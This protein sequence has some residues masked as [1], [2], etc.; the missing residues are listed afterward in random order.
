MQRQ[1]QLSR[2]DTRKRCTRSAPL[3]LIKKSCL[4]FEKWRQFKFHLLLSVVFLVIRFQ[5]FSH[6]YTLQQS[7]RYSFTRDVQHARNV[8][9]ISTY[10]ANEE[11]LDKIFQTKE[12][13]I[14]W[15][16]S[17]NLDSM[18]LVIKRLDFLAFLRREQFL[19]KEE[20]IFLYDGRNNNINTD[21]WMY[22]RNSV[23]YQ[24]LSLLLWKLEF[25]TKELY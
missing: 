3:F 15:N 11:T 14:V 23:L 5:L 12:N 8:K 2:Y 6:C 9:S 1:K 4:S 21:L 10:L 22:F 20:N 7:V 13:R 16:S 24:S 17:R 19:M 25:L 18:Y